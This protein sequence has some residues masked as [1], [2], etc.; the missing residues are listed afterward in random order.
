MQLN[1]LTTPVVDKNLI[2]F[3]QSKERDSRISLFL[4]GT[5]EACYHYQLPGDVTG[6]LANEGTIFV[7]ISEWMTGNWPLT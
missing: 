1:K 5:A 2:R 7:C 4:P 6:R 3:Q